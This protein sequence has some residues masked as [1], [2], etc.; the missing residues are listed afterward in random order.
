MVG[1]IGNKRMSQ[2][3]LTDIENGD[4]GRRF[5][6][7]FARPRI[8]VGLPGPCPATKL[9]A[10]ASSGSRDSERS[11]NNVSGYQPLRWMGLSRTRAA[12]LATGVDA[13]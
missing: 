1:T 5:L 13:G 3:Y 12:G 6:L 4:F 2:D 9:E 8:T 7:L 11:Q 10:G